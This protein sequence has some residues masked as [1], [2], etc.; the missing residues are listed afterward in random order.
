MAEERTR[1]GR[2]AA[3]ARRWKAASRA[4][5]LVL[6][7][8][9]GAGLAAAKQAA[10]SPV[11]DQAPAEAARAGLGSILAKSLPR[12]QIRVIDGDTI[13]VA[14][15]T[16]D[17]AGIDAPELGQSCR[18]RATPTPCGIDA[19]RDLKKIIGLR[20]VQCSMARQQPAPGAGG[21]DRLVSSVVC[22]SGE[23]DI[24]EILL[25]RGAVAAAESSFPNYLLAEQSARSARLGIWRGPFIA[26][27]RWREGERPV[28]DLAP[29]DDPADADVPATG[30][31]GVACPVRI[32]A[33]GRYHV[34][35]DSGYA[36]VAAVRSLCS[37]EEARAEGFTRP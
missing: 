13:E 17:L 16:L 26:P 30:L 14:G 34:P 7:L 3:S 19:A 21:V 35:T 4:A 10:P 24:A 25:R 31:Q 8:A 5:C 27:A 28:E 32:D 15:Q 22:M 12:D 11:A 33:D 20:P 18:N 6:V 37:D 2:G 1:P 23:E 36:A 9:T 29:A